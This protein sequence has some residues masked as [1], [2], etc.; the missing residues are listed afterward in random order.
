MLLIIK[1]SKLIEEFV[2][3]I[4]LYL[5]QKGVP[6]FFNCYLLWYGIQRVLNYRFKKLK[7]DRL[8]HEDFLRS[9]FFE[10]FSYHLGTKIK[11]KILQWFVL[12]KNFRRRGQQSSPRGTIKTT[13]LLNFL[14]P[15]QD[16][17]QPYHSKN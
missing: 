5:F 2:W 15:K 3:I 6:K 12:I 9:K 17:R 1:W 10:G 4:F 8:W 16:F 7:E 11:D 13:M 14:S